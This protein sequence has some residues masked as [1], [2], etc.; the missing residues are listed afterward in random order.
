MIKN[1]KWF[2]EK[3]F[4]KINPPETKDKM[5]LKTLNLV[6]FFCSTTYSKTLGTFVDKIGFFLQV[7]QLIAPSE[8]KVPQT[9]VRIN[10]DLN[11]VSEPNNLGQRR[12]SKRDTGSLST[13]N[14][15]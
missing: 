11:T 10:N 15:Q 14:L 7:C 1:Q 13:S 8:L 9:T 2:R 4:L 5:T 6:E 12:I 3:D